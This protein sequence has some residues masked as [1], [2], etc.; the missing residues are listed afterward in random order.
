MI[1]IRPE[2]EPNPRRRAL[3][4]ESSASGTSRL[5]GG[6]PEAVCSGV[7]SAALWWSRCE[8]RPIRS[9]GLSLRDEIAVRRASG[10]LSHRRAR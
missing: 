2:P 6:H 9:Y 1:H 5:S 10:W 3:L 7:V 4:H 8:P